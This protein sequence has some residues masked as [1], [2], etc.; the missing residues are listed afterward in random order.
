VSP[1]TAF[2]LPSP[3]LTMRRSMKELSGS[4]PCPPVTPSLPS[5]PNNS[6][7]CI[8]PIR[9]DDPWMHPHTH[10]HTRTHHASQH[11]GGQ[12]LVQ[13]VDHQNLLLMKHRPGGSIDAGRCDMEVRVRA[14][15]C[16]RVAD[17]KVMVRV[18]RA[19]FLLLPANTHTHGPALA[20]LTWSRRPRRPA[21]CPH[22]CPG[23]A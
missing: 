22:Q 15:E 21:P 13:A 9:P 3:A 10:T 7:S 12:D 14:C 5:W 6:I 8:R 23:S 2:T 11:E 20:A 4:G 1:S 19:L 18:E 17:T 16:V